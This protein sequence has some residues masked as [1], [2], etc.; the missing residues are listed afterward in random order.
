LNFIDHLKE[1]IPEGADEGPIQEHLLPHAEIIF[2]CAC[3][4]SRKVHDA[5]DL[6]QETFY[7]A[8]KNF[9]QL[10][11]LDKARNWLFAILKN[12]FLK[13]L[14]KNKKRVDIHFDAISNTLSGVTNL[15]NEFL[16]VETQKAV[17]DVL[18]KLDDRLKRPIE[19]FYYEKLSYKEIAKSLDLPIGTVMSRIARGK[20]YLKRELDQVESFKDNL[21]I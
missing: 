13:D 5:E 9:H 18:G 16:R 14:E 20:V 15:E 7:Y 17:R 19:M 4:L 11:D 1:K 8:I 3:R 6:T 12:L 2:R 10:Q 21:E